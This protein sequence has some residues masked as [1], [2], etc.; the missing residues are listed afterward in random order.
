LPIRHGLRTGRKGSYVG[1]VVHNGES[2]RSTT[3]PPLQ[4]C[5]ISPGRGLGLL[6]WHAVRS[7]LTAD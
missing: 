4:K 1:R 6:S 3:G 5:R 7:G 2:D